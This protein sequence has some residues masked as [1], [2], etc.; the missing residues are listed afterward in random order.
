MDDALLVGVVN[1]PGHGLDQRGRLPRRL[2]R[3]PQLVTE[4]RTSY[5]LQGQE[6]LAVVLADFEDRHDVGDDEAALMCRLYKIAREPWDW[7]G[8]FRASI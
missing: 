6:E 4:T 3:L 7:P 5:E 1:R 8:R 2:G